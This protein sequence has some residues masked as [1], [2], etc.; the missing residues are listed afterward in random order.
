[1][2]YA[3][4]VTQERPSVAQ[5]VELKTFSSALDLDLSE[6]EQRLVHR[7]GWPSR[8]VK[9]LSLE[10][11]RFLFLIQKEGQKGPEALSLSPSE[12]IDEFWHMH[13]L[14]TKKYQEDSKK[15]F[16]NFLHHDPGNTKEFST[17]HANGFDLFQRL[18]KEEFREELM[19]FAFSWKDLLEKI[20]L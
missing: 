3:H 1:M 15:L 11:K 8:K 16:G 18:Y 2:V 12:Q 6:L 5:C 17:E 13:I 14:D 19:D 10:Y 9:M 4:V 7:F 20:G